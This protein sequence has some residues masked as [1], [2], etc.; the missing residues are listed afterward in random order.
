MTFGFFEL[1]KLAKTFFPTRRGWF[2]NK[3]Y[4]IQSSF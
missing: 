1:N 4:V 3:A 2:P